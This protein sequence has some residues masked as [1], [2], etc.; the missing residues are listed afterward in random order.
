MC[1]E[2]R[3]YSKKLI[4]EFGQEAII[5]NQI[6]EIFDSKEKAKDTEAFNN[7]WKSH[8]TDE[9]CKSKICNWA[10]ELYNNLRRFFSGGVFKLFTTKQVEWGAPEVIITKEH[11]ENSDI[12]ILN[13]KQ[14]VYRGM[15]K[16][17][18][19]SKIYRQSWTLDYEVANKFAHDTYS[20]WLERIVIMGV[21]HKN[22]VIYYDKNNKEQEVIIELGSIK[23]GCEYN[24]T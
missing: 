13:E 15:S 12:D 18:Y 7:F 5:F 16:E 11:V 4:N 2:A 24:K 22:N 20:G 1:V 6:L 10:Y 21:V 19:K 23:Q 17:E 3:T 14:I 8:G 9:D